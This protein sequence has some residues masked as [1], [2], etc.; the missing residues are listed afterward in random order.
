MASA[1]LA[2]RNES[3]WG[4]SGG[5]FMGKLPYS[6]PHPHLNP[7]RKPNSITKK[8]QFHA[9]AG[10]INRRHADDSPAVTQTAS[11]DAYSFNQRSIESNSR[12]DFNH[13]GYINFNIASYTRSELIELKKR[14]VSE[15]NRIRNLSDRIESGKFQSRSHD[16]SQ[17]PGKIKKVTGKKRPLPF[18]S[19]KDSNRLC[20]TS[21]D[22][23][24]NANANLMKLCRQVLT[25][26][27]KHKHSWIFNKPVDAASMG[28][29]DYHQ[30]IKH[31]MD[32]GTVKS[33]FGKNLYCTAID[34]AAD[35]RLTFNN[36]MLYN[37]KGDEVYVMAEQLLA[38][39][40][41]LFRPINQKLEGDHKDHVFA[42]ELQGSSWNSIPTPERAKRPKANPMPPT[43]K[44][45]ERMQN[46][47]CSSN[48][49]PSNPP[50]AQSPVP[51]PSPMRAQPVKPLVTKTN[52]GKQPKPKAK[53]ENKREMSMEEK[54]KLGVGLQSLPPEKMPQLVQIIRKRNGH[55]AQEGDE[56]ELD[57]EAID[58]ETLWELDRFVTNWKKLE[59]KNRRQALMGNNLTAATDQSHS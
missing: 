19:D 53:D 46:P 33:N 5:G 35:V 56:I 34:F 47:S 54:H 1:V 29:H 59:S 39:F 2:S 58:T 4:Q 15:L 30:I 44:K 12:T 14:L 52:P 49:T 26:L 11:D 55:L 21:D 16:T 50:S 13:G 38:R 10:Q 20:Q 6:K 40:E 31:P 17:F 42:D 18:L 25:K 43:S 28:L 32:L 9:S 37:P 22:G 8:K 3:S 36:A 7:N 27:M 57:I 45:P 48:L 51:T 41:E 23:I 24:G